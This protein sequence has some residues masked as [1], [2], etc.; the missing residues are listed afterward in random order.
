VETVKGK[1]RLILAKTKYSTRMGGAQFS[2]VEDLM[3]GPY[4]GGAKGDPYIEARPNENPLRGNAGFGKVNSLPWKVIDQVA[5][6]E[7][8]ES[9]DGN[10]YFKKCP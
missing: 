5:V 1:Y 6:R 8:G 3:V 7:G 4:R 10:V 9:Q 2:G